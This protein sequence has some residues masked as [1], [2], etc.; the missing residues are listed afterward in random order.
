MDG[1]TTLALDVGRHWLMGFQADITRYIIAAPLSW[2]V[3]CV[4]LAPVLRSRKI[5]PDTP[6]AR[7]LVIEFLCSVRTVAVFST[8]TLATLGL[9]AAGLMWGGQWRNDGGPVWVVRSEE[10][11]SELQSPRTIR[12]RSRPTASTSARPPS[13]PASR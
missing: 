1:I 10:H 11:T 9:Q 7:Q 6:P 2:L 3:L 13:W 5:R 12:L 4:I 8:V